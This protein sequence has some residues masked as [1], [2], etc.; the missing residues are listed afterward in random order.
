MPGPLDKL[1]E[2]A[3]RASD[4]MQ[5]AAQNLA[6]LEVVGEAGAG[7]VQ[8]TLNGRREVSRV[9]IDPQL[10]GDPALLEDLTAGAMND[11]L[12]KLEKALGQKVGN[13]AGGLK[14]PGGFPGF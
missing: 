2:Q 9:R 3:R 13:L 1:F 6:K 10:L 12:R 7:M 11:A 8:V 4:D 5:R 14:M